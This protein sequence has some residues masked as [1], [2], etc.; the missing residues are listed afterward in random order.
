MFKVGDKLFIRTVTFHVIGKIEEIEGDW[1]RLS[2]ASWVAD[3][4]RFSAAIAAGNLTEL[5][6]LGDG[7]VNLATA[8]DIYPWL[9]D[10][11]VA[12]R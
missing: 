7:Y 6:Y 3:S 1:V 5:E 4:G 12:S 11:P 8:T 10:L 9:H 2:D